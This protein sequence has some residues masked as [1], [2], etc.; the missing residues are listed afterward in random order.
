MPYPPLFW[1]IT[2]CLRNPNPEAVLLLPIE[3]EPSGKES[4]MSGQG[5]PALLYKVSVFC[6]LGVVTVTSTMPASEK[7]R[8]PCSRTAKCGD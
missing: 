4:A 5:E 8:T 2:L 1:F 7:L 6:V 3:V